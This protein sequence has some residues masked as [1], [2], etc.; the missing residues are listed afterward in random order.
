MMWMPMKKHES[1][2]DTGMKKSGRYDRGF[3]IIEII[4][5]LIVLGILTAV[6]ISRGSSTATYT[7]RS[8]VDVI[9]THIRYAQA[10]AMNTSTVWGIRFRNSN[11]AYFLYRYVAG[12]NMWKN[13]VI[14]PGE[15]SAVVR[16]PSGMTLAFDSNGRVVSF[17]S[18]GVPYRNRAATRKQDGDW[19]NINVSFESDTEQIRIRKNTG[20][21]E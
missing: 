14:L 18:W 13:R 2:L 12:Q 6:I 10:R 11:T 9:K 20:F 4:V 7:L 1:S 15:A 17:D 21:I 19:R 3:T 5:V 16:L 8:E